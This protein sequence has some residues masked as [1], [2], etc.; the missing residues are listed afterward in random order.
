MK[1]ED[2]LFYMQGGK[3]NIY[4]VNSKKEIVKKVDTSPFFKFGNISN[5]EKFSDTIH[6]FIGEL[7]IGIMKPNLTV[8]YNDNTTSDIKSCKNFKII[9]Q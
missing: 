5:V 3:I 6:S 2:I 1:R 9:Y 4:L 7:H 8:L